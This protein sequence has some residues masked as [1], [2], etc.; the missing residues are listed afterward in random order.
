MDEETGCGC[1]VFIIGL[2]L[3]VVALGVLGLAMKFFHWAWS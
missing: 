3:C 1:F 2:I